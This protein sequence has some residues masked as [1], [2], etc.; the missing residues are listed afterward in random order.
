[1]LETVA[2]WSSGPAHPNIIPIRNVFHTKDFGDDPAVLCVVHDYIPQ[3]A[4]L[5][6]SLNGNLLPENIWWNY[7]MQL[8]R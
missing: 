1:M 4:A 2:G 8:L 7:T 3:A 5:H 6:P